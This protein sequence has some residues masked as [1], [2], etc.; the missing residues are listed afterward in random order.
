AFT[1]TSSTKHSYPKRGTPPDGALRHGKETTVM[2]GMALSEN[3]QS[4]WKGIRRGLVL[5]GALASVVALVHCGG[6]GDDG[7]GGGTSAP[8]PGSA[9]SQFAYVIASGAS[10]IQP[11]SVDGSGNLT[12]IGLPIATG[13]NPH[14]VDVDPQG[15]FVYVANHDSSFLSGWRINQDGTLAPMNP[16]AGSPVTGSDPT[17]NQPHSS[18][19]DRTG[20]FLY[21]VAGT[22]AS[23]LRAY[24]IDTTAGATLGTLTFIAGQSFP[25]STHAHNITISPNNQFVYVAVEN[26]T[27]EVHAFSRDIATGALT[28]VGVVTGMP[29]A[30]GVVVDLASKFVYVCYTNAVEVFSIGANGALTRIVPISTFPTNDAGGGAAPHSIAMH[31]SG[32]FLYTANLNGNSVSVF[33]VDSTTGA[34][35]E[36]QTPPV[37]T[38]REPNFVLVHPS[39]GFLYT[40]D[41]L[42]DQVSR[43]TI[44]SNGTLATPPTVTQAGDGADGI[45]MTN[46]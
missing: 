21:V 34:L 44:N 38:G 15:R 3:C 24:R 10:T 40:P 28:P 5:I 14:H 1:V 27:G 16:G 45:G 23:T 32:T 41:S 20:Q 12:A 6:G 7:G 42:D 4:K 31:P 29:L 8:P 33:S 37:P 9:T 35:A 22:A 11:N 18:V 19:I 13:T 2:N 30:G 17:E 25:V 39:G 43:F 46:F 36:L 26:A